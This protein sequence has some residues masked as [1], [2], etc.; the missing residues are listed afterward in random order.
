MLV[1][2][3]KFFIISLFS[4]TPSTYNRTAPYAFNNILVFNNNSK[5]KKGERETTWQCHVI[6]SY[7]PL[8]S[9]SPEQSEHE[10]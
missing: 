6:L 2:T 9:Q 5:T 1:C 8:K 4:T 10:G 3:S 7:T